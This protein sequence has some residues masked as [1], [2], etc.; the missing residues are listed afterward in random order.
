[1]HDDDSA[2]EALGALAGEPVPM[3]TT[4]V[5][6]V[7]RKGKRRLRVQRIATTGGAA[8]VVAVIAAGTLLLQRGTPQ[9]TVPVASQPTAPS[10]SNA[11]TGY[12]PVT[13]G[14]PDTDIQAST[15][16]PPAT[17]T[18]P[19]PP[20]S[21]PILTTTTTRLPTSVTV[22]GGDC[23]AVFLSPASM[24]GLPQK[25]VDQSFLH[26]YYTATRHNP[27]ALRP[28]GRDI[29]DK[30]TNVVQRVIAEERNGELVLDLWEHSGT[31]QQA[32]NSALGSA[33][34]CMSP[35]RKTLPDGT[36]M[37]LYARGSKAQILHV[38]APSGRTYVL[39]LI[40]DTGWPMSEE[41]LAAVADGVAKLG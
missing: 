12:T 3:A 1:M 34:E 28:G 17:D 36:V 22:T 16:A 26:A 33:P 7:I 20:P 35:R 30:S 19:G 18:G 21:S 40:P 15:I 8:V 39:T 37:Q 5:D 23:G 9:S 27:V 29:A 38:F 11:L 32:A 41:Q 10:S 4:T 25:T 31:P 24:P 13:P 14:P 6:E 2:G